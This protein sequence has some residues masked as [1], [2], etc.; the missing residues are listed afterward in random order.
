MSFSPSPRTRMYLS[1]VS[2]VALISAFLISG[3]LSSSVAYASS[4]SSVTTFQGKHGVKLPAYSGHLNLTSQV[5][6][7]SASHKPLMPFIGRVHGAISF[8][9]IQSNAPL[10]SSSGMGSDAGKVLHNFDGL[11]S[12]DSFNANG[13]TL[14]PPDQGLCVGNLNGTKVVG[15]AI[16]D[17]FAFYTPGGTLIGSKIDL[18]TFFQAPPPTTVVGTG[19]PRCYFDASTN[20]WFF[21]AYE[22]DFATYAQVDLLVLNAS[23]LAETVYRFDTT[24][25]VGS[26]ICPCFGDQPHLGV[27]SQNVYISFDEFGLTTNAFDG[28]VLFAIS[29]SQLAAGGST[30]FVTFGPV[31]LAGIP[32]TTLQPAFTT[33]HSNQE[34]LLNSFPFDAQGNN[35]TFSK[36]LGLW[37]LSDTKSVTAGGMPELSGTTITS[38]LYAFPTPALST[39]GLSLA[40][41]F[42]DPRMQQ[43]QYINGQLW[44]ALGTA[45][46]FQGSPVPFD[47]VA[48]FE[49]HPK[50]D[51]SG[52]IAGAKFTHQ[53]YI[54]SPGEY[55]IYP[56]IEHT[57]EGKTGIAFSLTSPTINP[58]TGYVVSGSD[59]VSFGSV[60][61]TGVGSGPDIGFT[62]TIGFPQQ[63]RWGDYSWATLDPN[64]QGIW[65]ASEYIVPPVAT[66]V[67]N[68]APAPTNWGTRIW[69]VAG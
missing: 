12:V 59:G 57:A 21:S 35:A 43:V 11:N 24:N 16:N 19:D 6:Q 60:H 15:E 62:C 52:M 3:A 22:S 17:V 45:L 7:A 10:S 53:G 30:N 50:V 4:S 44:A 39:N 27:D 69:E 8:S 49:I 31:S 23:T 37:V 20:T 67:F 40:T 32:I 41:Y 66:G 47:G 9:G 68:G 61:V 28:A 56:A 64:G 36:T 1:L 29:K 14:E 34:F 33:S 42:N 38:E 5:H 2:I 51:S 46:L 63:C 54:G 58:S 48:W 26:S 13:F 25:A 55:L 18:N 65:M